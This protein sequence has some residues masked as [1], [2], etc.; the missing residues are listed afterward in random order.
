MNLDQQHDDENVKSFA[1]P[2][3]KEHE[4]NKRK[5]MTWTINCSIYRRKWSEN[6]NSKSK[7]K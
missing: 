3:D 2:S 5:I 1:A 7:S 6:I 4:K